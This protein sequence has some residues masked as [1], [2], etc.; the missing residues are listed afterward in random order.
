MKREFLKGLELTDEQ[1]DKIMA[2]NGKDIQTTKEKFSDYEDVKGKLA[3]YKKTIEE[4]QGKAGNAEE[5]TAELEKLK[6]ELKA[7]EEAQANE[8]KDKQLTDNIVNAFGEKKFIN[9]YTRNALISEIKSELAKPENAGKGVADIFT[10]L[11][12]DK[13]GIFANET[14]P[15]PNMGTAG[16][17]GKITG[18]PSKMDY[19]TYKLWRSQQ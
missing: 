12:T 10:A 15:P 3:E 16:A 1:I 2:E 19:D 7:K 13:E 4:L 9:D 6:S 11:T 8:L 17:D 5:V 18:D 14:T